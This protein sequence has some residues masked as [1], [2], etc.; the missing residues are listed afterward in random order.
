M[1]GGIHH[2]D[3][4][5]HVERA[6]L[7]SGIDDVVVGHLP[8]TGLRQQQRL[9]PIQIAPVHEERVLIRDRPHPTRL[10]DSHL[11]TP[12]CHRQ[13]HPTDEIAV[14]CLPGVEIAM[15]VV[16][17]HH[18]VHTPA[19]QAG[20]DRKD[21]A[22]VACVDHRHGI[23]RHCV[24]NERRQLGHASHL[25]VRGEVGIDQRVW[26]GDIEPRQPVAHVERHRIAHG[27]TLQRGPH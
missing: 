9:L 26:L 1:S 24:G 22:A 18:R 8:H 17:H 14:G 13:R 11:T 27:V 20:D 16:E 12:G 6:V 21:D 7:G 19:L 2:I 25:G 4:H 10:G 5:V 3:I 23:G 15:R